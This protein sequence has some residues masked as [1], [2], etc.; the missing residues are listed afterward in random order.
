MKVIIYILLLALSGC[1]N[2]QEYTNYNQDLKPPSI[3][4]LTVESSNSIRI[5]CN[6]KVNFIEKAYF[7]REKIEIESYE[8]GDKSFRLN[9]KTHMIP[10]RE[11]CSEFYIE[12]LNGNSL[13]FVAKYYGYN[14][15]IPDILINEFIC[16]GT[17]SNPDKIELYIKKSGNLAGIALFNGVSRDYDS[18]FVFPDIKVNKGDYIIV[19]SV[20]EKYPDSFIETNDLNIANDRKF[21]E[22]VRDIR[23]KNFSLSSTN[24]V[25]SVYTD[26]YGTIIDSVIYSKNTNNPEKRYR[27]FG[28]KKT[29]E[30]VDLV[31]N[32]DEWK[33]VSSCIFPDDAVFVGNSTT[34]RSLNRRSLLDSN[35][36]N[37]WYTVPTSKSTFGFENSTEEY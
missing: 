27:N 36:D 35:T 17:N 21:I 31:G 3:E 6:E 30:R 20:S 32:I 4:R 7:S 28:L 2:I 25:I 16:K 15:S 9:F 37:D 14:K 8:L 24:G 13:A 10:G 11:Y 1:N 29:V 33:G 22:G 26:P 18:M 12:D 5:N 23:T 34:T 19:R